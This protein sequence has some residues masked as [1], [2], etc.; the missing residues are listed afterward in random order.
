MSKAAVLFLLHDNMDLLE[1][2]FAIVDDRMQS[3]FS[4]V[5]YCVYEND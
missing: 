3:T 1:R 5:L 2:N 4:E